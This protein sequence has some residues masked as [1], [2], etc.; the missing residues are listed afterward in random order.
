M[1]RFVMV[2]MARSGS[3][4]LQF[5]LNLHPH[6]KARKELL[7]KTFE[8]MTDAELIRTGFSAKP[9]AKAVG[10]KLLHEQIA[11]RPWTLTR[12]LDAGAKVIVLERRNQVERLRSDAQA[13]VTGRWEVHTPPPRLPAVSLDPQLTL[14]WMRTA[15]AFHRQLRE[16]DPE[17][18]LWL[19]YENFDISPVWPFLGVKDPGPLDPGTVRQEDRPLIETLT[20]HAEVAGL[21]AGTP[22]AWMLR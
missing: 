18:L 1:I 13:H 8:R 5:S 6:V 22:Y 19:T 9:P 10:F 16:I 15:E 14:W 21:L 20:N 11:G 4:H 7:N 2:T 12:L 3:H 17:R